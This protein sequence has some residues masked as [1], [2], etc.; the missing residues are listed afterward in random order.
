MM[1]KQYEKGAKSQR[2]FVVWI[3]LSVALLFPGQ[4]HGEGRLYSSSS[5]LAF[6]STT[7]TTA[8]RKTSRYK[9][10]TLPFLHMSFFGGEEYSDF[11]DFESDSD[12]D[13]EDDDEDDFLDDLSVADFRSKMSNLFDEGSDSSSSSSS[14]DDLIAFARKQGS[15]ETAPTDWAKPTS[16]IRPGTVLVANPASFCSDIGQARVQPELLSKFGLTLPPPADLGP[17]RRADLLPVLVVVE[18]NERRTRAVLLNRRTGYLLG[19]LEQPNDT[20]LLEK[21]CIQPLWFGGVDN[22]SNGGLDILHLC[23]GVAGATQITEDGLWWGGE[24]SQASEALE[25]TLDRVYTG[26]DF[27]FFV[28]STIWSNDEIEKEIQA[29]TWFPASV[30]KEVLFKPR[31]RMGTRRAKPLWTE[32][33]ELMGEKYRDIRDQLYD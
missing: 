6:R 28:Q 8:A 15:S 33:M 14:V 17:D 29:E 30:S 12:D 20:A 26:F 22:V 1:T 16:S 3:L 24:S 10:T 18:R 32:I 7:I 27:K 21:F 25:K 23:P 2:L 9:T 31:D 19:D 5:C 4:E 13:D 11:D